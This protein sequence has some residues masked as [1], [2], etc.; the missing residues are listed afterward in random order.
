MR[1]QEKAQSTLIDPGT[2]QAYRETDYVVHTDAPVTLKVDVASPGLLA[3]YKGRRVN[4]CIFITAW[5]PE[6]RRLPDV[7]NAARQDVLARELRFRSLSFIEG[8]GQ[9]PSNRW[10]PEPSFLVLGLPLEAAKSLGSRHE[11]NAIVWCGA[12]ATPALILLR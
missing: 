12:D 2:V 7:D 4:S 10:P 3:M 9:H 11:Q 5:N 6:S 8:V 1:N